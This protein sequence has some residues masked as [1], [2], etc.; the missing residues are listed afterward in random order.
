MR[1]RAILA[2][3]LAL[4]AGVAAPCSAAAVEIPTGDAQAILAKLNTPCL[5]AQA[6]PTSTASPSAAFLRP[7]RGPVALALTLVAATGRGA[8]RSGAGAAAAPDHH[9]ERSRRRRCPPPTPSPTASGR[10]PPIYV[11][12]VTPAPSPTPR[13]SPP[14]AR[15]TGDA[16][17]P[18]T[19]QAAETLGPNDYAVLGDELVGNREGSVGPHRARQ[20]PV[21]DGAL[22]GDRAHY[23]GERYIDVTGNTYFAEPQGRLDPGRRHDSLRHWTQRATMINGRGVTTQGVQNGGCTSSRARS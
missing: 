22:I 12:P 7:D 10:P 3:G 21:Q 20:H 19:P 17:P 6:G 2:I 4:I 15:S 18:P 11:V 23:D 1:L 13:P 9:P 5:V 14:P 8:A 16:D